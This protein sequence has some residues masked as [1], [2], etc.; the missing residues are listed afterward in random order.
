[1]INYRVDDLDQVLAALRAEGLRIDAGGQL[2]FDQSS[3]WWWIRRK[4][5]ELET[6]FGEWMVEQARAEERP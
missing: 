3:G 4:P 2:E 1:M 6:A 5:V